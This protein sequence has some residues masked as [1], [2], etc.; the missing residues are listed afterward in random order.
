MI[1]ED[2]IMDGAV[3][4]R[5]SSTWSQTLKPGS[6][7]ITGETLE[8]LRA[9]EEVLAIWGVLAKLKYREQ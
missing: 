7:S 8:T 6:L 2:G 9:A 4:S 1:K 5:G 3:H